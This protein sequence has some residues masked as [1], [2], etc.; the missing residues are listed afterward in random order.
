MPRPG[1]RRL[2]GHPGGRAP[3]RSASCRSTRARASAAT[4]SRSTRPTWPGSPAATP[5]GR[6]RLVELAQDINAEMPDYV[7]RAAS[8]TPS[9]PAGSR[10]GTP[11]SSPSASPTSRTS[12]TSASPRPCEVLAQLAR[13]GVRVRFH[14]PFVDR[15]SRARPAAAP[16]AGSRRRSAA[17]VDAVAL[18][19]P[20]DQYDLE[21]GDASMPGWSST[22]ATRSAAATTTR[23]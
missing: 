23:W 6:F 15:V 11:T 3:S 4:A 12:V 5:A 17:G 9:T 10:C 19:T 20:H 8:S 16:H 18:L 1:H 2:G 13:R 21:S 14:D 7:D 22:P